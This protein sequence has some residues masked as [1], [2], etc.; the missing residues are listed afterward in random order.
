MSNLRL[1]ID[2]LPKGAWGNDFSRTLSKK[3]WDTLR[4]HAYAKANHRCV[5]CGNKDSK[6]DAHEVWDFDVGT[7]TQTLKI[8][9][10]SVLLVTE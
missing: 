9:S 2:L 5:I 6:L 8:L 10:H 3:D 4:N 1:T 7:K